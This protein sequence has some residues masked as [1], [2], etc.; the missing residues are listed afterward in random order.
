MNK[1][2]VMLAIAFLMFF[3][4]CNKTV[5][6]I[7]PSG[8]CDK[9]K[10]VIDSVYPDF[11]TAS[12]NLDIEYLEKI[13]SNE[14]QQKYAN[15]LQLLMRGQTDSAEAGLSSLV[16]DSTDTCIRNESKMLLETVYLAD[17]KWAD[18][19]K[20]HPKPEN[21]TDIYFSH[22]KAWSSFP[23]ADYIFPENGISVPLKFT[24]NGQPLVYVVINGKGYWFIIDTG[25]QFSVI[26]EKVANACGVHPIETGGMNAKTMFSNPGLIPII[27]IGEGE[28]RK[29]PVMIIQSKNLDIRFL[30]LFTLMKI[31]G[32][33]G[34]PQ[35][36]NMRIEF[37]NV[38]RTLKISK[39]A[40]LAQNG[41][42]FFFYFR[43]LVKTIASNGTPLFFLFDA[44]KGYTSLFPRGARK[45]RFE[46]I[47]KGISVSSMI[48]PMGGTDI[49]RIT[50]QKNAGFCI[51]NDFLMFNEIKI[52]KNDNPFFDGWMGMDVCKNGTLIF[53]FP[54][55]EFQIRNP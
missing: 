35:I 3:F 16:T 9:E 36:K 42:N 47:K 31:D 44:G 27:S 20:I 12:R 15:A 48:T 37:D 18:L 7:D 11:I 51:Q 34:W 1:Q 24:R 54:K 17:S 46:I 49:Q 21:A 30:G 4:A 25:S 52:E 41:G 33:I 28:I 50:V 6:K 10:T 23:P 22:S 14:A 2:Y 19:L 5:V 13:A 26:S 32:I 55:G 40:H 38:H 43:P 53:D 45:T 29:V 8:T 39:S